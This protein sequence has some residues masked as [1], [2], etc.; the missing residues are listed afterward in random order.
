MLLPAPA[1]LGELQDRDNV[2]TYTLLLFT[3]T[4]FYILWLTHH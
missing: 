4:D 3:H 1:W 2:P